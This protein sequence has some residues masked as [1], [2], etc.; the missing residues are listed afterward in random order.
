MQSEG[1]FSCKA[2]P[3]NLT[4]S[5]NAVQALCTLCLS[6]QR[7]HDDSAMF[8]ADGNVS[9]RNSEGSMNLL[10]WVEN[11]EIKKLKW[12][13]QLVLMQWQAGLEGGVL[14]N[15][16]TRVCLAPAVDS[17][18]K[19]SVAFRSRIA[20]SLCLGCSQGKPRCIEYM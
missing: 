5:I 3:S 7:L 12:Q 9:K 18:Q 4:A 20:V 14:A 1:S 10:A 2:Q 15:H 6:K 17:V 19:S 13:N 11:V 16:S 8:C